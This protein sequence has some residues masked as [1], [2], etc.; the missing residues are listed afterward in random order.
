[1]IVMLLEE[2]GGAQPAIVPELMLVGADDEGRT[3]A[4]RVAHQLRRRGVR[5]E[6]DHRGRSVKAQMK[7]ADRA[8]ALTV[9]VL[10]EREI[11]SGQ[12]QV[13]HMA[14]GTVQE[15]RLEPDTLQATLRALLQPGAG[16]S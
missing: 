1:R 6:V 14:T 4:H 10:G 2:S 12:V 15:V 11:E 5:V 8:G 3:A 7:R 9:V 13:K 16:S